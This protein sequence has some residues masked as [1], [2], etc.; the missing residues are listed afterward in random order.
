MLAQST[1]R[2]AKHILGF[3]HPRT[4][5]ARNREAFA[6]RQT[7][8][9]LDA[10]AL[11]EPLLADCERIL[12]AEHPDTLITRN[13]LARAYYDA[14][15]VEEAIAIDEP[16]LADRERILGAEHPDTLSDP[17]PPR[18]RLPG[19][20]TRGRGDRDLAAAARRP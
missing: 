12:G 13:D 1:V 20:R 19:R 4:L 8:R 6:Y 9:T 17:K 18:S 3:E 11:L 15:R 5:T 16:L 10:I 7:G 14:G 2:K